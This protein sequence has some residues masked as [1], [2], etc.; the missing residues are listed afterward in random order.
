MRNL[1]IVDDHAIVRRGLK[2]LFAEIGS[3]VVIGE[4]SD[5]DEAIA[6]SRK[7]KY[8]LV[9]LDISMPGKNGIEVMEQILAEQPE[10]KVILLSIYPE[11]HYA[12]RGIKAG[13][14]GYLN[15]DCPPDELLSAARKVLTGGRYISSNLA[16][17][18]AFEMSGEVDK[19]KHSQLSNREHEVLI[20]IVQGDSINEI[21]E[22]LFIS[23]KTVSTYK[24][25]ILEKL[26]L[27]NSAQLTYY[28]VKNN[29]IE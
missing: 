16:E 7:E 22:E 29:L 21:A 13:A 10:T 14:K 2:D 9:I 25:R 26:Q 27:K 4:A 17:I 24:T 5:G 8:D 19:P 12:I 23:A 28:A 11:E 6:K 1:L 18:M 15:K 20:K 3:D